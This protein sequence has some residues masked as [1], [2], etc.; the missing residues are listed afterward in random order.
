M[1]G[2]VSTP[3]YD[4]TYN[5]VDYV[6]REIRFNN[7]RPLWLGG[8]SGSAGSVSPPGGYV[9]VL[10]QN[11]VAYDS[12]EAEY[13]SG[14]STLMDNL[15]HDRYRLTKYMRQ[16]AS[17][18]DS[19]G[20]ICEISSISAGSAPSWGSGADI[21]GF[22][23]GSPDCDPTVQDAIQYVWNHRNDGVTVASYYTWHTFVFTISGDLE[24]EAGALEYA[25]PGPMTLSEVYVRI[26]TAPIGQDAILDLNVNGATALDASKITIP[27]GDDTP[28]T[29]TPTTTDLVKNDYLTLDTDQRGTTTPGADV[30]VHAR[31]KQYL[32]ED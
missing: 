18:Q 29:I 16:L 6:N 2:P 10:P 9:G 22:S 14:G 26:G 3:V 15:A 5:M 27:D 12:T 19:G 11:R 1:P 20:S 23:P 24:V 7:L 8:E 25:V 30:V 28:L 31:C 4:P 17:Y 32:Q 21:V 13:G